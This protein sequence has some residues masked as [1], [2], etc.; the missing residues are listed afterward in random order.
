MQVCKF[1]ET[2]G[3]LTYPAVLSLLCTLQRSRL[4]TG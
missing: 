2:F 1:V 3:I 4:V